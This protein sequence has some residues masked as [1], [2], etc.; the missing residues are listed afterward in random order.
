[1]FIKTRLTEE[2]EKQRK[3]ISGYYAQLQDMKL[4]QQHREDMNYCPKCRMTR[5]RKGK[6]SMGCD[7]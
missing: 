6:C 5:T 3:R 7:D 1:M 4:I 2:E